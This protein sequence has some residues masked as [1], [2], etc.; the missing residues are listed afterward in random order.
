VYD[1]PP[2]V[3]IEMLLLLPPHIVSIVWS[4]DGV[5]GQGAKT[6]LSSRW[7]RTRPDLWAVRMSMK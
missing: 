7:T 5:S 4:L 3:D 1:Y 2:P 6:M